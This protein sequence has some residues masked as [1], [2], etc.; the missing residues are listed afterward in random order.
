MMMMMMMMMMMT[1]M[2]M[3]MMIMM[4]M[5]MPGQ[6][7]NTH[8]PERVYKLLIVNPSGFLAPLFRMVRG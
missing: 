2:M 7:L 1:M 3:M 6:V 8:Y 4:M 5:M